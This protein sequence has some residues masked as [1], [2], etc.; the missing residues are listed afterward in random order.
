[1]KTKLITATLVAFVMTMSQGQIK[2]PI[3]KTPGPIV[4]KDPAKDTGN[5]QKKLFS[6]KIGKTI[7]TNKINVPFNNIVK[8]RTFQE[9]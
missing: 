6:D 4:K 8:K 9:A 2:G 7:L 3:I 5:Q 1:M